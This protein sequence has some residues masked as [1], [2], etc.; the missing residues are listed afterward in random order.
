[1]LPHGPVSG[2]GHTGFPGISG[3]KTEAARARRVAPKKGTWASWPWK[4][5]PSL[6][7]EARVLNSPTVVGPADQFCPRPAMTRA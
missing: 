2:R 3:D 7:S 4:V 5:H 1:M 6:S